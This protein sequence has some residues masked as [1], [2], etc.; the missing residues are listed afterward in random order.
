MT[1][2]QK[3]PLRPFEEGE[4]SYLEQ[5]SRARSAPVEEVIRARILL[6][7]ADGMGYEQAARSVGRKS[8]DAVSHLVSRFNQEG[9][10][11]LEP[12]HGGG[13][14]IVYG[15]PEKARILQEARR[16][17]NLEQDGCTQWSLS[18]LQKALRKAPDGFPG[19]SI[20]TIF[21]TL[22]E[23]G[24]SVQADGS[25]CETGSAERKRKAGIVTVIDPDT[26]AKKS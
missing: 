2:R 23:A 3:D 18:L 24:F 9:I 1:R 12:R 20:W 4:R 25:W 13:P 22:H 7:V 16:Q 5:V 15:Q 8:G 10:A 11:A 14:A 19:I 6:A 26:A 17:P 21:H